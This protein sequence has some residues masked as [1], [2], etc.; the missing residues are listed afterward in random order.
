MFTG[1]RY[2]ADGAAED[3]SFRGTADNVGWRDQRY[4]G[5]YERTGKFTV[6]GIWDE[7]PQFYSVDTKTP[8]TGV[9]GD[10]ALDDATQLAIQNGRRRRPRSFRSRISSSSGNGATSAR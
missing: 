6:S 1:A 5:G 3:W 9:S 4:I 7:I 10:L 2:A 8:F